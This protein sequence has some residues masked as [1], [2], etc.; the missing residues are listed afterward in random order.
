MMQALD[1]ARE[2]AVLKEE[3]SRL[4]RELAELVQTSELEAGPAGSLI[5]QGPHEP[6]DGWTARASSADARTA[7]LLT[8]VVPRS[9]ALDCGLFGGSPQCRV[10]VD[11]RVME[12]RR[13]RVD[14]GGRERR[15]RD[16]RSAQL[17]TPGA[18]LVSLRSEPV[19]QPERRVLDRAPT[20]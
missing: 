4:R 2:N 13:A 11:R 9:L 12:R 10:I 1:L 20:A 18:L 17:E 7:A 16:R 14:H 8:L 15:R 19:A 3:V 6:G 5:V